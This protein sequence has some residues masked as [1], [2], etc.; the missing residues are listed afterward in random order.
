YLVAIPDTQLGR[1]HQ[2]RVF[3]FQILPRSLSQRVYLLLVF[4]SFAFV[5]LPP[6]N[7]VVEGLNRKSMFPTR[8]C[9]YI[10]WYLTM[11]YPARQYPLVYFLLGLAIHPESFVC[12][13]P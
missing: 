2:S 12:Y 4:P 9:P 7:S 13:V 6:Y 10:S 3:S 8:P 1:C 5:R 11:A